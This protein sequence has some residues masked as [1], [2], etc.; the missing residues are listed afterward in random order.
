MKC[1]VTSQTLRQKKRKVKAAN[2]VALG[3]LSVV[4]FREAT[5]FTD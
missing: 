2:T 5:G 4:A 1:K 3:E